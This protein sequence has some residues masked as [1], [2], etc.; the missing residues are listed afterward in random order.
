ML[1]HQIHIIMERKNY[2]RQIIQSIESNPNSDLIVHLGH[3]AYDSKNHPALF[4][5]RAIEILQNLLNCKTHSFHELILGALCNFSSNKDGHSSIDLPLILSQWDS[6]SYLGQRSIACIF[7]YLN[8]NL[9][10][11]ESTDRVTQNILQCITLANFS[12]S[13]GFSK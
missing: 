2:L 7:Y 12:N 3:F 10:G 13:E 8:C 6:V 1:S 11:L 4:E 5:F 9:I